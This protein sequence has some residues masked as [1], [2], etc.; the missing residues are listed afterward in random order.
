[1]SKSNQNL[2]DPLLK[3]GNVYKIKCEKCNS[4][5]VQ[6]SDKEEPDYLCFECGGACKLIGCKIK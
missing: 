1:M 6:I 5:S 3:S 2:I 4:I